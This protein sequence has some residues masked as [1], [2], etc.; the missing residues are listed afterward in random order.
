M[1]EANHECI[2]LIRQE[3]DNYKDQ[4][5]NRK[6]IENTI[7]TSLADI[8]ISDFSSNLHYVDVPL[9]NVLSIDR[10][11][12][13]WLSG[14][15]WIDVI[16]KRIRGDD[17][18][19]NVFEYFEGDILDQDFPAPNSRRYLELTSY[20]GLTICVNGNHRLVAAMCWL[21][22]K[23][24]DNYHLKKV[25]TNIIPFN[26][27]R[28]LLFKSLCSNSNEIY[29]CRTLSEHEQRKLNSDHIF[30][31]DGRFF[32]I[33]NDIEEIKV[34]NDSIFYN[35]FRSDSMIKEN[36]E[37]KRILEQCN[38]LKIPPEVSNLLCKDQWFDSVIHTHNK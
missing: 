30:N 21:A 34:K 35:L 12:D 4:L 2:N 24:G 3:C 19:S 26:K 6:I 28:L 13:T 27:D 5:L 31:A 1:S 36:K 8:L 18:T 20:N 14:Q 9:K 16:R 7:I 15:S 32:K 11:G 37:I 22:T 17:W 38:W 10:I 33:E 29:L 25:R 23:F